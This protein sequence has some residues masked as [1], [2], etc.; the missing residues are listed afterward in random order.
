MI[1]PDNGFICPRWS[2]NTVGGFRNITEAY[3]MLAIYSYS[4]LI[5]DFLHGSGAGWLALSYQTPILSHS[6]IF[7]YSGKWFSLSS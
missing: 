7:V 4:S 2:Q 6:P 3:E 1:L 5:S